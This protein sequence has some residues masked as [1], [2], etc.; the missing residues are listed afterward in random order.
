MYPRLVVLEG[1]GLQRRHHISEQGAVI[2]FVRSLQPL[3]SRPGAQAPDTSRSVRRI[4]VVFYWYNPKWD[5]YAKDT[6]LI[7]TL[8]L[9]SSGAVPGHPQSREDIDKGW[10]EQG[11][12]YVL[13]DGQAPVLRCDQ[14][15]ISGGLRRVTPNGVAI[16]EGAGVV[17]R[18]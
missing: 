1:D 9:P 6:L 3:E 16:L 17:R 8:P 18:R 10:A 2:Q 15:L 13:P 5:K 12:L 11:R 14:C 7:P 4:D